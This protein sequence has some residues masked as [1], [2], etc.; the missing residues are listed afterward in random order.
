MKVIAKEDNE[1]IMTISDVLFSETILSINVPYTVLSFDAD[2]NKETARD[3]IQRRWLIDGAEN[4]PV[5]TSSGTQLFKDGE[6]VDLIENEYNAAIRNFYNDA[7][8]SLDLMQSISLPNT[9][10]AEVLATVG[11]LR[12]IIQGT[13]DP[14]RPGL[15]EI[16]EKTLR[17]IK[18][19]LVDGD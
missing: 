3:L 10:T 5:Y 15:A 6:P 18:N 13:T 2:V 17:Y 16:L 12:A 14:N 19:N 1:I 9:T 11:K 8:P 4:E 7:M